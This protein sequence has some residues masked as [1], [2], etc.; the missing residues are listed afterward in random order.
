MSFISSVKLG[1]WGDD[2]MK[3]IVE[4]YGH[5]KKKGKV[6]AKRNADPNETVKELKQIKQV[7]IAEVFPRDKLRNYSVGLRRKILFCFSSKPPQACSCRYNCSIHT[8]EC[9]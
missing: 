1:T 8:S 2:N 3:K 6:D 9:D 5:E 7:A 4:H